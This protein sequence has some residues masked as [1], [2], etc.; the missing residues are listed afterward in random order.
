MMIIVLL[1]GIYQKMDHTEVTQL[2]CNNNKNI[3]F[4]AIILAGPGFLIFALI[5]ACY[6]S[7]LFASFLLK[8]Y[9]ARSSFTHFSHD[10]LGRPF[11]FFTVISNSITS[12]MLELIYLQ[13]S[14]QH[15]PYPEEQPTPY[16]P[17]LPPHIL[18]MQCSTPRNLTS[19]ATVSSHVLQN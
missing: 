12:R 11:L 3:R 16:R 10:F 8:P 9:H 17:V 6:F 5:C 13:S 19:C 1:L 4:N 7:R 18:I 2:I 15:P 14:Q